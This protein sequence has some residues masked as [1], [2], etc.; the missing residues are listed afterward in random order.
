GSGGDLTGGAVERNRGICVAGQ[1]AWL[2]IG[3]AGRAA[4]VRSAHRVDQRADRLTE[5]PVVGQGSSVARRANRSRIVGDP[6][7]DRIAYNEG[8]V[9]A[10]V[11]ILR[12]IQI[13]V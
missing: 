1:R 6:V 9:D 4:P 13:R 7:E 5:T 3:D 10:V 2:A 8:A 11:L 12:A